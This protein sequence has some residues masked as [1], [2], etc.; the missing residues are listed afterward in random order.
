[1]KEGISIIFPCLKICTLKPTTQAKVLGWVGYF[2]L[3]IGTMVAY[4]AYAAINGDKDYG[5]HDGPMPLYSNMFR[6][7]PLAGNLTFAMGSVLLCMGLIMHRALLTERV[8]GLFFSAASVSSLSSLGVVASAEDYGF[9]EIEVA[10]NL[11]TCLFI[12]G[13]F[14]TFSML[15]RYNM[16]FEEDYMTWKIKGMYFLQACIGFFGS[17]GLTAGS[18]MLFN[19]MTQEWL[20]TLA[21]CEFLLLLFYTVGY[22]ILIYGHWLFP[23]D[24]PAIPDRYRWWI[25]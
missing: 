8:P 2:L 10:H 1:M 15:V 14:M 4:V 5:N 9:R 19:G 6:F 22:G 24:Y 11:F 25:W 7:W 16:R 17:L 20:Q 12:V 13:A 3:F 21:A 18:I 23:K